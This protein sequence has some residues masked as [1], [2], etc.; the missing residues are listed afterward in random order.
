[1]RSLFISLVAL[2]ALICVSACDREDRRQRATYLPEGD[3]AKGEMYFVSLGCIS[4]H[5][6]IGAELP[7]PVEAG[8]VRVLLGSR[9]GR[10]MFYGQL[11]TSI[12]N[13]SH[14]LSARS[15]ILATS[16]VVWWLSRIWPIESSSQAW[17]I[18]VIWLILTIGFEF[19][20]GHYV[21]G[22]S[23]EKLLAD[24][25]IL[26]GRVWSLFLVWMAVMSF[27]F[28]KLTSRAA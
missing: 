3:A 6:V 24:Y 28:F 26:N 25:N 11:V 8:P 7:D 27:V 16:A 5:S 14:R 9:T 15:G 4:C 13:P 17:T 10:R 1:M 23:W 22:N 2:C 18:G 12:V 19:G 20:F 21:A